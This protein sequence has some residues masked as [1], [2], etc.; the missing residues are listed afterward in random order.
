MKSFANFNP[1]T[2]WRFTRQCA[3]ELRYLMVVGC[4]WFL[5]ISGQAQTCTGSLGDPVVRITFGTGGQTS[6]PLA[7]PGASTTYN[8]VAP[9]GVCIPDG[10]Y[11]VASTA[12]PSVG[13]G[14]G[15]VEESWHLVGQDHT[16][17]DVNGRFAIINAA[18]DPGEFYRQTVS[19]LCGNTTYELA[20]YVGNLLG[21]DICG[22]IEI[23]PNLRFQVESLGGAVLASYVTGDIPATNTFQ[24]TQFGFVFRT[25]ASTTSVVLKIIN[26][27]PGGCGNDL[28]LDD[29]TFRPCGPTVNVASPVATICEGGSV[30]L[31]GVVSSGYTAPV[32]LWQQSTDNGANWIGIIGA[33]ALTYNIVNAVAGTRYRMLV[34]ENG[35]LNNAT[36]RIASNIA[37]LTIN[38]STAPEPTTPANAQVCV[39]TAIDL[40]DFTSSPTAIYNWTADNTMLGLGQGSGAGQVPTFTATGSGIIN[41][42]VRSTLNGCVSPPKSFSIRIN[43]NPTPPTASPTA[44][45]CQGEAIPALSATVGAGET[46]DWYSAATGGVAIATGTLSYTPTGAGTFYA[47]TR[48]TTTNCKS[49]TRTAV[50]LTVNPLPTLILTSNPVC[51]VDLLVYSFTFTSNGTVTASAGTISGNTVSGV[52]SNTNVTLTVTDATTG[53]RISR[54]IVGPNCLCPPP[55]PLI[56]SPNVIL[57]VGD[58]IPTLRVFVT[59]NATADWYATATSETPLATGTVSYKPPGIATVNTALYVI[60]RGIFADCPLLSVSRVPIS[61]NVKTCADTVDLALKTLINKKIAKIGDELVYT[62]KV[63]NQSNTRATGVEVTDSI[64]TTV[65][66][67]AGSFAASRGSAVIAGNVIKWN[68][69]NIAAAGDTVTLSYKVKATQAGLH[70]KTAEIS[71]TNEKDKDSTPGNGKDGEDDIDNQCFTVPFE[72]CSGEKVLATVPAQ[73]TNV[74]WRKTVNGQTTQVGTSNELLLSE[75]GSYS[76]TA[77]NQ[78]CPASGCCPIIIEPGDNCCPAEICVPFTVKEVKGQ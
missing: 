40:V 7:A 52:L 8:Y 65:Q 5:A 62:I 27:A 32:Y 22:P 14:S 63:F 23:R 61:I 60:A 36:C 43:P 26:E 59:V 49:A 25:P 67:V 73:Y 53:C 68:V 31:S 24:W 46:V 13:I 20:S 69:G 11:T 17:N 34:A 71:K 42:T 3:S 28:A 30:T 21:S 38:V 78:T 37:N 1:I 77:T 54:I 48:N 70:F 2:F 64:A 9:P 75:L 4:L 15:C 19:G 45:I 56:I 18:N 44:P 50:S 66:F 29:I 33:N 35:N 6:F 10:S 12:G 47:E 16:P 76:F 72:L 39:G 57:C 58:T 41:F 74:V 55:N 51:S